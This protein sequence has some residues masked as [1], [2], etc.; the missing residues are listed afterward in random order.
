MNSVGIYKYQPPTMFLLL[1]FILWVNCINY[2]CTILGVQ[3]ITLLRFFFFSKQGL[4]DRAISALKNNKF[5]C[6]YT[7]IRGLSMKFSYKR[8]LVI[9]F[10]Y[11]WV[12]YVINLYYIELKPS[13]R[14]FV[15][16]I[17]SRS[18]LRFQLKVHIFS[19]LSKKQDKGVKGIMVYSICISIHNTHQNP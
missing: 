7:P 4:P 8:I 9:H 15:E 12:V 13:K 10:Q 14:S 5:S 17:D 2:L 6:V 3:L 16:N 18:L 19:F 1:C 11:K